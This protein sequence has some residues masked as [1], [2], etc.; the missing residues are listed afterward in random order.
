MT[1]SAPLSLPQPDDRRR[2]T[3][4]TR[5]NSSVARFLNKFK[6]LFVAV[7]NR[8]G[9]RLVLQKTK[10][11]HSPKTKDQRWRHFSANKRIPLLYLHSRVRSP[12]SSRSVLWS[13][14]ISKVFINSLLISPAHFQSSFNYCTSLVNY[15]HCPGWERI[16]RMTAVD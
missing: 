11:T 5:N 10:S 9:R 6:F 12:A 7:T 13:G 8:S 15:R 14:P 16:E 1:H 2:T 4:W 3:L